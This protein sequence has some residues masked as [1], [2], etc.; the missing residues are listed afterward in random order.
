M[1]SQHW[2]EVDAAFAAVLDLSESEQ[3]A[4]IARELE[5]RP[6]LR[7]EVE[8][9]LRAHRAAGPFLEPDAGRRIGP[10]RIIEK[11][12]AGGMGAVFRAER[13][14]EQ[15]QQQV[16]IKM[17]G[18]GLDVQPEVVRRFLDERQILASLAHP[19]IARLLDGGYTASGAPYLVMEYVDG[20]PITAYCE[21]HNL[22]M[23]ARLRLFVQLSGAV[24][25]AHRRLVIHRDLKPA[26][27]LVTAEGAPKLLDFGIAKL[28]DSNG[29]QTGTLAPAMTPDYASPEQVRGA[30]MTTATDVYSLGVLLYELVAGKPPY[31]LSGK[32]LEQAVEQI[33]TRDPAAPSSV[34]PSSVATRRVPED[35]DAIVLKAMRK[36]PAERYASVKEMADDIDRHLS[37][38]P[39]LARRGTVRYVALKFVR[40]NRVGVAV[41]AAVAVALFAAGASV[42]WQAHVARQERDRAERRF[43]EVRRLARSVIFDLHDKIAALPGST[44]VR[45][46]LISTAIGYVDRLAKEAPE[47]P[48]LRTELAESY[49]RIADVQ[50]NPTK[51]N[52]GDPKG[53][54]ESY[55]KAERLARDLIAAK[56]TLEARWLLGAILQSEV[57]INNSAKNR[58]KAEAYAAEAVEVAREMV[59]SAPDNDGAQRQLAAALNSMAE[60]SSDQGQLTYREQSAAVYEALLA[61]KPSDPDR[62][63]NVALMHKYIAGYLLNKSEFGRAFPHL[64]RAMSLDERRVQAAPGDPQAKMDLSMDISQF[65]SYYQQRK[66]IPK[67]IEYTQKAVA[68][69]REM[70]AADPK[71]MWTQE[72]LAFALRRLGYLQLKPAPRDALSHYQEARAIGERLQPSGSRKTLAIA[73]S[74]AGIGDAHAG[75][76]ERQAACAAYA[77][78]SRLFEQI[79]GNDPLLTGSEAT[80]AA[81][82]AAHKSCQARLMWSRNP[83]V[84]NAH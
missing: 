18:A 6:D 5:G 4:Y 13:Q 34:A 73:L 48:A 16:A 72:R 1:S 70:A 69:R 80:P 60:I 3:A 37:S 45:K 28:L 31:S 24:E 15:F 29:G 55:A 49:L 71:E 32:G 22:G 74:L 50:G 46:D 40:R 8:S 23:E 62:M 42:V 82:E 53:A 43:N 12:G 63:R 21:R 35:L 25:F 30:P 65:G 59:R 78:S 26:N 66:E 20:V 83:R 51:Q 14:D 58:D 36:E 47:D 84:Q 17:I 77:E 54:M 68:I 81:V 75:L 76:G 64:E 27:I 33:C 2:T 57:S 38:R 19:H 56:P 61:R 44:A 39:V 10:Y 7:A 11:I 52:L 41:A 67:A 79:P 9:L